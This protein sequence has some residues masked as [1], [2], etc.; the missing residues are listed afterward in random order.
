MGAKPRVRLRSEVIG[1]LG[2]AIMSELILAPFR[3]L[4]SIALALVTWTARVT[5]T[6]LLRLERHRQRRTL[7][8]LGDHV[9]KDMGPSRADVDREVRKRFWRG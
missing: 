4:G 8:E 3:L 7:D 6:L 2:E 1:H 9:L 5:D